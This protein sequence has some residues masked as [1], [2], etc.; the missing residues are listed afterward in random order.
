MFLC[1]PE[2][3]CLHLQSLSWQKELLDSKAKTTANIEELERL[4]P[5]LQEAEGEDKMSAINRA[6]EKA[7]A[8]ERASV[9]AQVFARCVTSVCKAHKSMISLQR[10][11]T[12]GF[13]QVP[14]APA[15]PAQAEPAQAEPA[16]IK[17]VEVSDEAKREI[18]SHTIEKLLHLLYFSQ[19]HLL[20][21]TVCSFV[22]YCV[23]HTASEQGLRTDVVSAVQTFD[24]DKPGEL[25]S[26]ERNACLCYYNQHPDR[27]SKQA[28]QSISLVPVVLL[29]MP[30]P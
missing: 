18:Q 23:T 27:V 21:K 29:H 26:L 6:V 15:E 11:V 8:D 28:S 30:R 7:L 25:S 17:P 14:S 13:F 1:I 22:Q 5:L 2:S 10:L 20:S 24:F 19:V 16:L 4:I 12:M 3:I 9:A